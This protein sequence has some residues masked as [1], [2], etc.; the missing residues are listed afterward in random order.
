MHTCTYAST[1]Q[2]A[3][4]SIQRPQLSQELSR[5]EATQRINNAV[6]TARTAHELLEREL[7]DF[8]RPLLLLRKVRVGST[9][10]LAL[11]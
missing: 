10:L 3:A 5:R 6:S 2:T 11:R 4:P 9:L 8:K 7:S 1:A